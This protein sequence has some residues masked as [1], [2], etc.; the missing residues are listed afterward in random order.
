MLRNYQ[1]EGVDWLVRTEVGILADDMGLGKTVQAIKAIEQLFND[2][3]IGNCIIVSPLSL[4]KNWEIEISKWAP[5]LI[6]NRLTSSKSSDTDLMKLISSSNIILTN[7]ENLREVSDFFEN[8]NFD[9]MVADEVHKIRK[10]SSQVSQSIFNFKKKRFWGLTGTPVENNIEDLLTLLGHLTGQVML[11]AD[12]GRSKLYLLETIKPYILRRMKSQVLSELPEVTEREY[13]VQLLD[14]QSKEYKEIWKN[15][16]AIINDEGSY[17]SVL[18]RLRKICDG[19]KNYKQNSKVLAAGEL[20]ENIKNNNEKVIIFS[21]YLDPLYALID[22]LKKTDIEYVKFFDVD[23]Q[24]R[25]EGIDR[26]KSED[27]VTAFVAS[28]RIASEGLTLTEANNVI[29]LNRWWNPSSNSQARDRVVRIGQERPV[30]IYNL[31]CS[32]TIEERVS[33]ILNEKEGLYTQV[34]D[35]LVDDLSEISKELLDE[36]EA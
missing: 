18:S 36:R 25:E 29:F 35:G 21:Y 12:K 6:F 5:Q 20:I 8:F 30:T 26:F 15:R 27:S 2:E 7:Y 31:Y 28:S 11:P 4:Q 10:T 34:L 1:K 14:N 16:Q 23:V 13:A 33:E 24:E 22:Y 17:F 3:E 19:D 32:G 9:L